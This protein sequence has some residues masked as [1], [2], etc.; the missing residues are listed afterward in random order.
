MSAKIRS[1]RM[2]DALMLGVCR[3]CNIRMAFEPKTLEQYTNVGD[4]AGLG[5]RTQRMR[6]TV[7]KQKQVTG[8]KSPSRAFVGVLLA[9]GKGHF[10]EEEEALEHVRQLKRQ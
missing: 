2:S 4:M 5:W 3:N 9:A 1:L 7:C 6:R 10:V 8:Y